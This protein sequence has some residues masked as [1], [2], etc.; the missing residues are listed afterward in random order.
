[1]NKKI[2]TRFFLLALVPI[3]VNTSTSNEVYAS[4]KWQNPL[5]QG[6]ILTAVWL[7]DQ[8]H[9][10]ALGYGSTIIQSSDRGEAARHTAYIHAL[11][12]QR[13][14]SACA[15]FRHSHRDMAR[16]DL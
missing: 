16:A 11:W 1:M 2:S 5:P 15:D 13:R 3:V 14:R 4:W 9:I 7:A 12:L 8:D 10:Y 6:N